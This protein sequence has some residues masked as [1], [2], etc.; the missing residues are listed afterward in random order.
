MNK[1]R[2]RL[3]IAQFDT[4]TGKLNRPKWIGGRQA[5]FYVNVLHNSNDRKMGEELHRLK[6]REKVMSE[7]FAEL[8]EELD[9]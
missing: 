9:K 3:H 2:D 1:L 5:I 6:E 4:R 7:W 8:L